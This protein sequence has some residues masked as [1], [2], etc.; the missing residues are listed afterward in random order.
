MHKLF[1][2]L[3]SLGLV[4][5]LSCVSLTASAIDRSTYNAVVGYGS[6]I[7]AD[8]IFISSTVGGEPDVSIGGFTKNTGTAAYNTF[9]YVSTDKQISGVQGHSLVNI[10]LGTIT[11]TVKVNSSLASYLRGSTQFVAYLA[12]SPINGTSAGWIEGSSVIP[13]TWTYT[14]EQSGAHDTITKSGTGSKITFDLFDLDGIFSITIKWD[15]G[16]KS[17]K[18]PNYSGDSVYLGF[19]TITTTYTGTATSDTA[20]Q[21]EVIDGIN[22]SNS[23]L[24]EVSNGIN[25]VWQAI[26][27]LPGK[28]ADSFKGLFIPDESQINILRGKWQ[29]FLTTKMGFIYQ[30]FQWVDTF[31]DGIIDN[32]TGNDTGVL[33]IPAFP[34]FEAGGETVQLW[35][36]PLTVDFSDNVF[37]Q[38]LQPI[39]CPFILG[40][41]AY[42]L[43]FAMSDL[44]ECF[45][46]GKSYRD[47]SHR[48]D[49]E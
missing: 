21:D 6:K 14:V 29:E 37:V 35:S 13:V 32:L 46:A 24:S 33:E 12:S 22:E 3:V 16:I 40:V 47:Y 31:F 18:L 20:K 8:D 1:R 10:N 15:F 44:M 11:Q 48:G 17:M 27:N 45:F 23:L 38:T 26:V 30:M 9:Q 36:E 41:T 43:W 2:C 4:W 5:C 7:S 34:A 25:S 42:H 28:I 39:A 19:R 49:D